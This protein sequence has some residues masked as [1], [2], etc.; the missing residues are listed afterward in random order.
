MYRTSGLTDEERRQLM[1]WPD[2]VRC[3]EHP[4]DQPG[5]VRLPNVQDYVRA[6]GFSPDLLLFRTF[7]C[8]PMRHG[9]LHAS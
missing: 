9:A 1:G 8:K 2:G 5:V 3:L 4:G 7:Q 6:L